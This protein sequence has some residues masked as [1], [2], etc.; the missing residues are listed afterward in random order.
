MDGKTLIYTKC[1]LCS[2]RALYPLAPPNLHDVVLWCNEILTFYLIILLSVKLKTL[3]TYSFFLFVFFL[4]GGGDNHLV[5]IYTFANTV[6]T[7][8]Y[9]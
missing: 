5:R 9:N 4:G 1:F 6:L 8:Y 2:I 7:T 3:S